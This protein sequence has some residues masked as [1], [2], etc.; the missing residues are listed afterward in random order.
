MN[1]LCSLLNAA[2]IKYKIPVKLLT[3][4]KKKREPVLAI[5]GNGDEQKAINVK[6]RIIQVSKF[7]EW[8]L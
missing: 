8:P 5:G 7:S 2:I 6:V 3:S 1:R 4:P